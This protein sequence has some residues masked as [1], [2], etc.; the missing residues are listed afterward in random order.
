MICHARR[1]HQEGAMRTCATCKT[2]KTLEAFVKRSIRP[3]GRGYICKVCNYAKLKDWRARNPEKR[4]AQVRKW[5]QKNPSKV[6]LYAR[7]WRK[8][9]PEKNFAAALR[10]NQKMTVAEYETMERAQE[11]RCAICRKLPKGRKN[12]GRLCVDH[13]HNTGIKRGLLCHACNTGIGNL[14]HDSTILQSAINY[15]SR[16]SR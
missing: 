5:R 11:G 4:R 8:R 6:A 9:Y 2:E 12:N 1:T 3:D 15:L 13:C 16:T 14:Q 7:I 10:S